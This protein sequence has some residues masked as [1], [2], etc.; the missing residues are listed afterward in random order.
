MCE[1]P[2]CSAMWQKRVC[3]CD[4]FHSAHLRVPIIQ[5]GL[6]Q[7]WEPL[8]AERRGGSGAVGGAA[9]PRSRRAQGLEGRG[10]EGTQEGCQQG[11]EPKSGSPGELD[12]ADRKSELRTGSFP[13]ASRQGLGLKVGI[14]WALSSG[15]HL[16]VSGEIVVWAEIPALGPP[17]WRACLP[18]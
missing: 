8:K 9:A 11:T 15:K 17:L 3:R 6:V 1:P 2:V 7:A 16:P 18:T 5:V 12:S 10:K 13:S 4:S 14:C